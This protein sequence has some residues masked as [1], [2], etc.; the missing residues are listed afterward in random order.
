MGA[1]HGVAAPTQ[2]QRDYVEG[3]RKRLHLSRPLLENHCVTRF[4]RGLNALDRTQMSDLLDEMTRWES[5]PGLLLV[6]AGQREL[7]GL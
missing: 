6:E 7:P 3:I 2:K 5:I 1:T 4:G